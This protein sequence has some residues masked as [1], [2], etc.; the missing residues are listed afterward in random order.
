MKRYGFLAI[1]CVMAARQQPPAGR[2][3][4][5][6]PPEFT[7][8]Q[9]GQYQV[10]IAGLDAMVNGLRASHVNEDPIASTSGCTAATTA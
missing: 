4:G 9:K 5:A 3:R 8:G 2:G 1:A 7:S 10:I 6:P